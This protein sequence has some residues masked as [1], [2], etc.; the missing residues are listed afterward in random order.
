AAPPHE[1]PLPEPPA[2]AAVPALP[3]NTT[4]KVATLS[5]PVVPPPPVLPAG[6][7]PQIAIVIDDMGLSQSGSRR[8]INLPGFVTLS[9]LPYAERLEEQAAA[10]QDKGH[11]LMLHMPM[12]P[13]GPQHPGPGGLFV[14]QSADEIR[15]R[16]VR[17]LDS[18][19]GFDGMNNHMGS[20]F[21]AYAPGMEIVMEEI[22]RRRLFYLD[23]RTGPKSVGEAVARRHGLPVLGRDVFLDDSLSP[24]AVRAQLDA[25]ERVAR[26]KGYAI[27]IGHP[28]DVTLAAL[29]SWIPDAERRG[30]V[31]VPVRELLKNGLV[32]VKGP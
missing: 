5:I 21:T 28:H 23:S 13:V 25:T 6:H 2:G 26:R 9:F 20:K 15:R 14:N 19:E 12:E 10:A 31:F 18:F 16:F 8:A 17:A 24:H 29:E 1:F 30:F 32:Q 3:E 4:A 11:E 27:A 22:D 7:K